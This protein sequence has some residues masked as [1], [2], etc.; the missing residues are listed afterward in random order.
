MTVV[1][2]RLFNL[3]MKQEV[4]TEVLPGSTGTKDIH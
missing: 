3:S 4:T 1:S 2:Q